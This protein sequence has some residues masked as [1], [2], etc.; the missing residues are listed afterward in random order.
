MENK[1]DVSSFGK[2]IPARRKE[3]GLNQAQ[4]AEIIWEQ[5]INRTNSTNAP[6]AIKEQKRKNI[7]NYENGKF[8]KDGAIYY[9]LCEVLD[10][11]MDYL[12]GLIDTPKHAHADIMEETGLSELAV[13]NLLAYAGAPDEGKMDELI[14]GSLH[15][16]L[17][18]YEIGRFAKIRFIELLLEN[19][20]EL[21]RLAVAAYDYRRQMQ[22][23]EGSPL[24]DINGIRHDQ[25]A[26][27]AKE[28]AK[29]AL[30][31]LLE[32][33]KWDTFSEEFTGK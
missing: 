15:D 28:E 4:L 9:R 30:S 11:D 31:A 3:L 25:F 32:K 5:E 7:C 13:A 19:S 17:R 20:D 1:I 2:N 33:I 14:T 23:Y 26:G 6:S 8:P 16:N 21:E 22:L 10:C 29:E 24:H 27:V 18:A 12:F